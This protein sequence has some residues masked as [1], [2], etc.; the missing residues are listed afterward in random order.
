VHHQLVII[1]ELIGKIENIETIAIGDK[2]HDVARLRKMYGR[3]R[4][5]KLKGVGRVRLADGSECDAELH[6]YEAHGIGKKEM[7]VKQLLD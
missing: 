7:K 4:W 1:F 6:W 2:I 5:R 3:G